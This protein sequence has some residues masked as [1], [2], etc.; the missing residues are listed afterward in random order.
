MEELK[1]RDLVRDFPAGPRGEKTE[2]EAQGQ[3]GPLAEWH[4]LCRKN[5]QKRK[6]P[7]R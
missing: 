6:N 1:L 5:A 3:E 4:R 7:G 2:K